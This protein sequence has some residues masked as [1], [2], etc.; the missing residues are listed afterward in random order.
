MRRD[1]ITKT[2]MKI[3]T[4]LIHDDPA[5]RKHIRLLLASEPDITVVGDRTR[6]DCAPQMIEDASLILAGAPLPQVADVLPRIAI[7]TATLIVTASSDRYAV[8]A[9]DVGAADYI[10]QPFTNERFR[11]ALRRART[12]LAGAP[13]SS[14]VLSASVAESSI[15]PSES[16]GMV[17]FKSDGRVHLLRET[18]IHW[19]EAEGN[20][21]RVHADAGTYLVRCTL[22]HLE[23]QLH[24]GRFVRVHRSTIV[25]VD[26]VRELCAGANG[27]HTITL[28]DNTALTLSRGYRDV[29]ERAIG[30]SL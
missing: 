9:F 21:V 26:V 7:G 28:R 30:H 2:S 13:R 12:R 16:C 11:L 19:C 24:A 10:L 20:Y 29:F 18:E 5:T 8:H 1:T 25:N 27:D 6:D 3:R 22:G 17:V 23:Q 15:R 4:L 14:P